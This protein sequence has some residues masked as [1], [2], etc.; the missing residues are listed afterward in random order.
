MAITDL[1][2]PADDGLDWYRALYGGQASPTAGAAG[3]FVPGGGAMQY[4]AASGQGPYLG[5]PAQSS[6]PL[7][8]IGL[9]NQKPWLSIG[10]PN[11]QFGGFHPGNAVNP[12]FWRDLQTTKSGIG[13]ILGAA[14]QG[15]PTDSGAL[16]GA[17]DTSLSTPSMLPQARGMAN[18]PFPAAAAAPGYDPLSSIRA[19]PAQSAS[20]MGPF[21]PRPY[22]PQ[23]LPGTARPINSANVPAAA[24]QP[25]SAVHPAVAAAAAQ[26]ANPHF[27]TFQYQVP[28]QGL[29]AAAGPMGDPRSRAPIYTAMNLGGLF[30]RGQPAAAPAATPM[31][32]GGGAT[33]YGIVRQSGVAGP[34]A[35]PGV[36][37]P[38]FSTLAPQIARARILAPNYYG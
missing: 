14:S 3:M 9:P 22:G 30:G 25:V 37:T 8:Q 5:Y 20:A 10:N 34:L 29:T 4:P 28:N 32:Q 16:V 11:V 17:G 23:L 1:S 24:A 7:F 21:Q 6:P 38:D 18:P 2:G 12:D 15:Q 19:N 33:P 26:A 13:G 27:S 35:N 31:G 36:G